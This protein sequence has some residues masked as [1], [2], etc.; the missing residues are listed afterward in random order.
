ME[1]EFTLQKN[2][3]FDDVSLAKISFLLNSSNAI[4]LL[5]FINIQNKKNKPGE[6]T[7]KIPVKWVHKVTQRK[8]PNIYRDLKY[9]VKNKILVDYDDGKGNYGWNLP[10]I[11]NQWLSLHKKP[12]PKRTEQHKERPPKLIFNQQDNLF[13]GF[14]N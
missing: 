13:E 8:K 7:F 10:S 14:L 4:V 12:E 5:H 1:K 9:L 6:N 3:W 11:N 2:F